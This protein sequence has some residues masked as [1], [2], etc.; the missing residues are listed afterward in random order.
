MMRRCSSCG[1]FARADSVCSVCGKPPYNVYGLSYQMCRWDDL[2][3]HLW[4]L[5]IE[6]GIRNTD[7]YLNVVWEA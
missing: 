6:M 7:Q 2:Q 1:K 4:R 5:T 3:R